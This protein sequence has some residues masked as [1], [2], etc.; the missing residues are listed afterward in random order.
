MSDGFPPQ[1]AKA[2]KDMVALLTAFHEK[3][4]IACDAIMRES[5][6]VDLL[7]CFVVFATSQCEHRAEYLGLSWE[8]FIQTYGL[9]I[10]ELTEGP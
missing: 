9:W 7:R 10:A 8:A 5:N 1:S 3:D 4:L 6:L 2:A